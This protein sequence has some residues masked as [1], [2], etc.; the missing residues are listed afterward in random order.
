MMELP[1][2]Q[3]TFFMVLSCDLDRGELQRRGYLVFINKI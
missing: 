1:N 3:Y 2:I